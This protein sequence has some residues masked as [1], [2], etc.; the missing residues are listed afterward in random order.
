MATTNQQARKEFKDLI[1]RKYWSNGLQITQDSIKQLW[2]QYLWSLFEKGE[3]DSKQRWTWKC[4]KFGRKT[5]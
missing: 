3:I 4:P 1:V 5:R 2:S